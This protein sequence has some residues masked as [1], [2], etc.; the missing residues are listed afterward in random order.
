MSASFDQGT[1]RI[2]AD[3][4]ASLSAP[5]RDRSIS[6]DDFLDQTV[7]ADPESDSD[8]DEDETPVTRAQ[9]RPRSQIRRSNSSF[10]LESDAEDDQSPAKKPR[11]DPTPPTAVTTPVSS[12]L[13]PKA[14]SPTPP[15]PPNSDTPSSRAASVSRSPISRAPVA[16]PAG[17]L[18][19][20]NVTAF[21]P[22]Q[23]SLP[24]PLNS[25]KIT[26]APVSP[27][28]LS[29]A[30]PRS[31]NALAT[32]PAPSLTLNPTPPTSTTPD[33]AF[34]SAKTAARPPK[35]TP[36]QPIV[37]TPPVPNHTPLTISPSVSAA[38]KLP[39]PLTSKPAP[40]TSNP[41][42]PVTTKP[43]SPGIKL[44][45]PATKKP[46]PP[47]PSVNSPM[48]NTLV[49]PVQPSPVHGSSPD[50]AVQ[51]TRS[52]QV[53]PL[54]H[55][56]LI[57]IWAPKVMDGSDWDRL[58]FFKHR[59]QR[60]DFG[61]S[62]YISDF[63]PFSAVVAEV[64]GSSPSSVCAVCGGAYNLTP[65]NG[66]VCAF[67]AKC[68]S[69]YPVTTAPWFCK[70]C[71]SA[72]VPDNKVPPIP[73]PPTNLTGA[74]QPLH[75][76]IVDAQEGNPMDLTLHPGLLKMF[77]D[78]Y[79]GHDWLQCSICKRRRLVMKGVLSESVD[80]P[81][82]CE[83]AFWLPQ[84]DRHCQSQMDPATQRAEKFINEQAALRP[85]R[86]KALFE[87]G[88]GDGSDDEDTIIKRSPKNVK[89][90]AKPLC[91]RSNKE[92][93]HVPNGVP[94]ST[95]TRPSEPIPDPMQ[96]SDNNGAENPRIVNTSRTFDEMEVDSIVKEPQTR[97]PLHLLWTALPNSR[98][99]AIRPMLQNMPLHLSRK[100][101]RLRPKQRLI[102]RNRKTVSVVLLRRR[103]M[104][105]KSC[106]GT[107]QVLN[108]MKP[109]RIR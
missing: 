78:Q 10:S 58:V 30:S 59:P 2:S 85:V 62:A 104:Y 83:N 21:Q 74:A 63:S 89:L 76:P 34:V 38:P 23:P 28:L 5:P 81:F 36:P 37:S 66:C 4:H 6:V 47:A 56:H 39:S 14:P 95:H 87:Y 92:D 29:G 71:R 80:L 93:T 50:H 20:L 49:Q 1:K 84:S 55:D 19:L 44:T 102:T 35:P 42:S 97:P 26:P 75:R 91:T 57:N 9:K 25:P 96:I 88:F 108:W 100:V 11:P 70:G 15:R 52:P 90:S 69:P 101:R 13:Q 79:G 18:S 45:S 103:M 67:H 41:P 22:P 48:Q 105:N 51:S 77:R 33:V 54:T 94:A 40:T 99:R 98:V 46:T 65:C 27:P 3:Q 31:P 82:N 64:G 17:S 24:L 7:Y 106:L 86:R 8:A 109:Q 60:Y 68:V 107:L 73:D 43:T 16:A 53:A 12:P 61:D 72:G 32:P